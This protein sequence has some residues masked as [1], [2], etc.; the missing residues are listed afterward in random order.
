ME[1]RTNVRKMATS[2]A[3]ID[4]LQSGK[5]NKFVGGGTSF[6]V[7]VSGKIT[8]FDFL[9]NYVPDK[10]TTDEWADMT[11]EEREKEGRLVEYFVVNTTTGNIAVSSLLQP[12]NSVTE[13]KK[14]EKKDGFY[15]PKTRNVQQWLNDEF[16][17]LFG[18][19]IECIAETDVKAA[20]R[21]RFDLTHR[22]YV[23]K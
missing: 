19:T 3:A 16:P 7:G 23:V 11:Q 21:Q 14:G 12:H 22:L 18:K 20:G 8:G 10:Q 9:Q 13:W 6:T 4:A 5:G 1:I 17:A 2:Q 15:E